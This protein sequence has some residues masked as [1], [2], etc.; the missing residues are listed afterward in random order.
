MVKF[1]RHVDSLRL[2]SNNS[3]SSALEKDRSPLYWVPYNHIKQE[4]IYSNATHDPEQAFIERWDECLQLACQDL[5]RAMRDVW[6]G[7][8]DELVKHESNHD[9]I[10]GIPPILAFQLYWS[11]EVDKPDATEE[12]ERNRRRMQEIMAQFNQLRTLAIANTES[13]RKLVKKYD[14]HHSSTLSG[15]LSGRLLPRLYS[16]SLSHSQFVLEVYTSTLRSILDQDQPPQV[17]ENRANT[18]EDDKGENDQLDHAMDDGDPHFTRLSKRSDSEYHHFK[19]VSARLE[20]WEWL[21]RLIKSIPA[22]QLQGLVA[23][24]GFHSTNDR[25][26]V[27]PLE[28][29][30]QAYEMAWSCGIHLCECD[31]ALTQDEQLV[32]A[33]DDDFHRLALNTKEGS[34][35]YKRVSDLTFQE[36]IALP[37]KSGIRPPL[38]LDVLSSAYAISSSA[39]TTSTTKAQLIIEIKPGHPN[40]ASALVR[41]LAKHPHLIPC[42]A[43]VMSFDLTIMHQFRQEMLLHTFEQSQSIDPK[44]LGWKPANA[45]SLLLSSSSS[46]M[47]SSILRKKP[48]VVH[49]RNQRSMSV[50]NYLQPPIPGLV[51]PGSSLPPRPPLSPGDKVRTVQHSSHSR[52]HLPKM[53]LLTIAQESHH[54]PPLELRLNIGSDD[55][56]GRID[57]WLKMASPS[58]PG[59]SSLDGVYLQFERDML[60]P[61]GA[62][63]LRQLSQRGYT[64]GIWGSARHND[65]DT[66]ESF[67]FLVNEGEASFVNTDLPSRFRKGI[68]VRQP[69]A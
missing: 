28:N 34:A 53:L 64:V 41:L 13:L 35:A 6:Q 32:L 29:S 43:V 52:N 62:S 21:Q 48:A 68:V 3:D 23:H 63:R 11:G 46:P 4:Y 39:T 69:T 24:R 25:S 7:I 9:S 61:E 26:D 17:E 49:S 36:L 37:L 19:S 1:G 45:S 2:Y 15:T 66:W 55:D 51:S 58:D 20:E 10:R 27:R 40:A 60:T 16:S 30:L 5:S 47:V 50:G 57:S 31:I 65:P 14:K 22:P 44:P 42:V 54:V 8:F 59:S 12:Q 33:H 38:L 18:S 56:L 67:S